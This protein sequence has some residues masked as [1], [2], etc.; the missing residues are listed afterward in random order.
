MWNMS[1]KLKNFVLFLVIVLSA[2][3]SF[4]W[5]DTEWWWPT[6]HPYHYNVKFKW[7]QFFRIYVHAIKCTCFFV[8][9]HW[10]WKTTSRNVASQLITGV[11]CESLVSKSPTLYN[12]SSGKHHKYL[13]KDVC[14]NNN[15]IFTTAC[16]IHFY[17]N[18][19][20]CSSH[21]HV[22]PIT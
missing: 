9:A 16:T 12:Q 21:L 18:K 2:G 17:S 15:E 8:P 7:I 10:N 1:C 13:I 5:K 22:L 11:C 3:F 19:H 6:S 14:K 20:N 4:A